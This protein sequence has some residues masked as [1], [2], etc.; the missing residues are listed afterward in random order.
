MAVRSSDQAGIGG[1]RSWIKPAGIPTSLRGSLFD[2][3]ADTAIMDFP[4]ASLL[5]S[6]IALTWLRIAVPPT[7]HVATP[8]LTA[9][10]ATPPVPSPGAAALASRPQPV[11][12]KF[13]YVSGAVATDGVFRL[14]YASSYDQTTTAQ[15]M[16]WMADAR[17]LDGFRIIGRVDAGGPASLEHDW[18]IASPAGVPG[19]KGTVDQRTLHGDASIF[20][21]YAD[22]YASPALAAAWHLPALAG[23]TRANLLDLTFHADGQAGAPFT[24]FPRAP[25]FGLAEPDAWET[26]GGGQDSANFELNGD[27]T[28]WFDPAAAKGLHDEIDFLWTGA[29]RAATL[30]LS[31]LQTA[32]GKTVRVQLFHQGRLVYAGSPAPI[33]ATG[34]FQPGNPSIATI[35]LIDPIGPDGQPVPLVFDELRLQATN[36]GFLVNGLT[37]TMLDNSTVPVGGQTVLLS[38]DLAAGSSQIVYNA[39]VPSGFGAA[40]ASSKG[41]GVLAIDN[42]SLERG[43][44]LTILRTDLVHLQIIPTNAGKDLAVHFIDEASD[45]ILL[46]G[47]GALDVGSF[48]QTLTLGGSMEVVLA[49]QPIFI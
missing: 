24:P 44:Q 23:Q 38:A 22:F 30:Q 48:V 21:S 46:R 19:E 40:L 18:T 34:R 28:D 2:A 4:D 11:V 1:T 49:K 36:G 8:T 26:A 3:I 47:A 31:L 15:L 35:S 39:P 16:R 7:S 42:F 17:G 9:A 14:G 27:Y 43:D 13:G 45:L 20:T 33:Q 37:L 29:A 32:Q 10:A 41:N 6:N 25:G 5:S 12:L